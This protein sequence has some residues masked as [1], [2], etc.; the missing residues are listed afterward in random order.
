VEVKRVCLDTSAYCQFKRG[1]PTAVEIVTAASEVLMI[2]ILP[3]PAV[4]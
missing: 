1:D 2:W 4:P 3:V